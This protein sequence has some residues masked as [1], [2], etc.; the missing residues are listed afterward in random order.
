MGQIGVVTWGPR[1]LLR[2]LEL[3]LGIQTRIVSEAVRIARWAARM[4]A[5]ES[6]TAFFSR[7]FAV[8]ALGTARALLRLRDSLVEAGWRGETIANSGPRL[9]AIAELEHQSEPPL[10]SGFVDR[11]ATVTDALR[12]QECAI[13]EQLTLAEPVELWPSLWQKTFSELER[14]GTQFDVQ[15]RSLPGAS[16]QNDLGRVQ[17]ALLGEPCE[18]LVGDGSF[19]LLTAPTA[20]EAACA[21]AAIVGELPPAE[22]VI[23]RAADAGLLDNALAAHGSRTQGW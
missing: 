18:A 9:Q 1:E 22:T 23:I 11:L 7:S 6:P 2:D 17:A 21:T 4:S 14:S 8:D 3:R 16:A 19:V 20:G 13:Y 10:P 12:Y 15:R 5:V